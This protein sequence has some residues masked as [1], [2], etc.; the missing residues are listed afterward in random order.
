M[1]LSW[2]LA[3]CLPACHDPVGSTAEP[4]NIVLVLVDD[5]GYGDVGCYGSDM[6]TPHID[7][8]AADGLRLTDYHSNGAMCSPTRAALLTGMYQN[9][10]GR[11]F[12]SALNGQTM[13]DVGLPHDLLTLPE[14]LQMCGYAT[15]LF[16]KWHLGYQTPNLPT[17]HGFDRFVGLL[18]GDGDHHTQISRWGSEDW[19][20]QEKVQMEEGYTTDLITDH[21]LQFMR[22]HEEQPFF[23]MVSHLAIHFPWQG[24][25]DPPHRQAGVKYDDD[26][27]GIIPDRT[28]VRPHVEAMIT[29]VDQSVGK[30]CDALE[31]LDLVRN[32]ILIFTSDNGGYLTYASGGF[33]NISSNGRFR[34][35][36]TEVFEGGHR[37]PF[38]V[39]WPGQIKSGSVSDA[40]AMTIDLYPTL[41]K[42]LQ[43][44]ISLD[45]PLDGV[46]L[47][48]HFTADTDLP[49]RTLFWK[50]DQSFAVRDGRYKLLR[51]APGPVA[52]FD[53]ANDLEEQVDLRDSLP[54][55]TARLRGAYDIWKARMQGS[56]YDIRYPAQ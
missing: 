46:P 33:S 26:K 27:W 49:E 5:L 24:P 44:K 16:G 8:L 54:Q 42:I 1:P 36:K 38:I 45:H 52:L 31:Q 55:I 14:M 41:L 19:W 25:D 47:L 40:T 50:M 34:G 10:L 18:S 51:E 17:D 3:L 21:T 43:P 39:R 6:V 9:R 13:P 22:D 37:V 53:L 15:G 20:H 48:D 2:V 12:E 32:T 29:A 56:S 11:P 35:Q 23:A 7:R 4:P 28:N 30:I